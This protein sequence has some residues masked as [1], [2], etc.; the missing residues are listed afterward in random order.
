MAEKGKIMIVRHEAHTGLSATFT[1]A[2]NL[3]APVKVTGPKT[4][5]VAAAGDTIV[6]VSHHT[7]TAQDITDG[8]DRGTIRLMGDVIPMVAG[9]AIVA[10]TLLTVGASGKVAARGAETAEDLIGVAWTTTTA[11]DQEILVIVK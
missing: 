3:G 5:G 8:A 4:V 7:V 9:A 6:G 1:A 2:T 11:V 10:G